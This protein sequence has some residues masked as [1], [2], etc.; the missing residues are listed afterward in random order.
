MTHRAEAKENRGRKEGER[1]KRKK[2]VLVI[3][4]K[5]QEYNEM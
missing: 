4:V 3:K 1:K 2:Q 5:G